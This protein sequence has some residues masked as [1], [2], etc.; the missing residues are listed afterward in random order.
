V[1]PRRT[2]ARC[3]GTTRPC[4]PTKA[5]LSAPERIR[6]EAALRAAH[7]S[8]AQVDDPQPR[9][10]HPWHFITNRST[11]LATLRLIGAIAGLAEDAPD[12]A[13]T[14]TYLGF[15][16]AD[17]GDSDRRDTPGAPGMQQP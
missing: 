1:S 12:S 11:T 3:S 16:E 14:P 10:A 4:S 17:I 2:C 5:S 6:L 8:G 15:F 7:R 13:Q 9:S